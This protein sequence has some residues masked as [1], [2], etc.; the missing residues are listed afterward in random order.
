M[1]NRVKSVVSKW[2]IHQQLQCFK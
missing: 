1:K 2:S